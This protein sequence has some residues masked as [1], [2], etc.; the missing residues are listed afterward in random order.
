DR[1][2][3]AHFIRDIGLPG[4]GSLDPVVWFGI[5]GAV[6]M[7]LGLVAS[8]YLVRRFEKVGQERL[9]RLLF[10]FSA[11]QVVTV[12]VF[13]LTGNFAVAAAGMWGYYLTRSLIDPVYNTWVNEQISDSS[14]RATV[15]SITGQSDAIGQVVGGPG[16]GALGSIFSIRVALLAGAALIAPALALYGRAIRHGGSEPE[17]SELS[18]T[19]G[20]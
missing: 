9:A 8:E 12:A 3:E 20:A 10:V 1:L 15:I 6:S 7:V 18:P 13:A 19:A 2:W 14:V 11:V 17:L 4:L 16:V 5:F